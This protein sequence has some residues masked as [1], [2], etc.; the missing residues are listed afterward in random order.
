MSPGNGALPAE[1]KGT[2][3]LPLPNNLQE[4]LSHQYDEQGGWADDLDTIAGGIGKNI[5]E[6]L[7]KAGAIWAKKTGSRSFTYDRNRIAMYTSTAF[8]SITLSWTLIPNNKE[9][10]E[11][12]QD[13]IM[14]FK[15]FSSPQSV[16]KKL[17]LRSPH[18]FR[19]KFP[20]TIIDKAMQFYE[21]VCTD[22]S[23]QYNPGGSMEMTYDNAPKAIELS[24]SFKDREPKLFEDWDQGIKAPGN[25][26]KTKCAS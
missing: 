18:Y 16:A 17:L 6:N 10:T 23:V 5:M 11:I 14:D 15:K 4:A 8:R 12:I 19:I 25:K 2:I 21:V 3:V 24:V 20:N 1:F 22:I 26:G 13:I 9:D 7:A